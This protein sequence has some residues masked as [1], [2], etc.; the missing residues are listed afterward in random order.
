MHAED[1]QKRFANRQVTTG[2]IVMFGLTGGVIPCPASIT[3][4]LICLRLKQY[5]MGVAVVL[6]FSIGLA[7]TMVTVGA[8]A[9]LSVNHVSKRWSG[10][11]SLARQAPYFSSILIICVG[12]YTGYLG[13]SQ[14]GLP[15][16]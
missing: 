16:G 3:V 15:H 1:I 13:W 9:A 4:L 14:L 6:C 8:A 10:F 7:V 12:L 5:A 11:G 2:Q